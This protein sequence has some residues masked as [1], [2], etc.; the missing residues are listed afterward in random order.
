[1]SLPDT[2]NLSLLQKSLQNE[3]LPEDARRMILQHT[4]ASGGAHHMCA[5]VEKEC[6]RQ[7]PWLDCTKDATWRELAID[8]FGGPN[9]DVAVIDRYKSE[10][11]AWLVDHNRAPETWKY[12]FSMLCSFYGILYRGMKGTPTTN[13]VLGNNRYL[14]AVFPR[15]HEFP[16]ARVYLQSSQ[17]T[18]PL[19]G[20]RPFLYFDVVPNGPVTNT[21]Y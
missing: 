20:M 19:G 13:M 11:D 8:I 14:M 12:T 2:S 4:G 15:F 1:M 17:L 10:K 3:K 7:A 5:F 16:G 9:A 6:A 21:R 18:T